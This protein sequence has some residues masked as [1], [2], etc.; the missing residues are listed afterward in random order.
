[1]KSFH[2]VLIIL[3]FTAPLL[4]GTVEPWSLAIMEIMCILLFSVWVMWQVR[5]GQMRV[6]FVRPPLLIPLGIILGIAVVQIIPLPPAFVKILS[7]QTYRVYSDAAL[8]PGNLPWLT[9]SLYPHAT[10]LEI[11]RLISYLCVYFLTLQLLRDPKSMDRAT[12]ALLITGVFVSF[13][14]MF[15]LVSWNRKVLWLREFHDG[16]P[17]GPYFNRNHFAG[18]MEMLIPVSIGLAIYLLP[19]VKND[20]G[21]KAAVSDFLTDVNANKL[22]LTMASVIIMITAF[23]LSL[24]RGGIV[25]LSLS[26]L[27]FGIMLLLR[28]S[29]KGR[30]WAIVCIFLVILFSVG[31]F[32]WKPMIGIIEKFESLKN[33]EGSMVSRVNNWKDSVGMVRDF[34]LFGTGLGTYEHVYPRYRTVPGEL[35]WEHAHNDYVEGAVELG[36]AGLMAGIY[37][38]GAFYLMMFRV[39]RQRKSLGSRLLGIGGMTGITAMAIHSLMDFNL[40]IGANGLFFSFLIGFS[41]AASHMKMTE[42]GHGTILRVKEVVVPSRNIRRLLVVSVMVICLLVSAVPFLNACADILFLIGNEQTNEGSDMLIE[43]D[44]I[45]KKAAALSPFDARYH[46]A[47]GNIA[48]TLGR[49][50]EAIRNYARAVALNPMNGEYMQLLGIALEGTGNPDSVDRYMRVAVENDP[51]SLWRHRNYALWL[52][53]KGRKEEG[54]NEI[55]KAI[56][57]D[58][59]NARKYITAAVLGGLTRDEVRSVIPQNAVSLML[60]GRYRE[61]MGDVEGAVQSYSEALSVMKAAGDVGSEVYL[62]IA[63]LYEKR[64]L[65]EQALAHYKDG[66][67]DVPSDRELRVR[68]ARLYEK[69]DMNERAIEQYEYL[70]TLNPSDRY[71]ERKIK[72]LSIK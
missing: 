3:L 64:G 68:L 46:F 12:A 44:R 1:M 29:T 67:K 9:L 31:W 11:I 5:N 45:F 22:I 49:R 28:S 51:A 62:R 71:A 50:P 59:S 60:Y 40:H 13:M 10:V 21:V 7:P 63:S 41:I 33:R 16:L 15:Q 47:L 34:P 43:K 53:S 35:K 24:S 36:I 37:A 42:N 65:T 38:L 8:S 48:L 26:M 70:L 32:G 39:L 19:S 4:F 25:A 72:E 2:Y 20:R 61:E 6:A 18:L 54:M 56:S 66:I 69:L 27:F 17:F 52:F 30:G 14:G 58:P 23:F 55:K 57:M